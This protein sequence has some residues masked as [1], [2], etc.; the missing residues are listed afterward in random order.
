MSHPP[1]SQTSAWRQL[2]GAV[3]ALWRLESA[4]WG[5]GVA[6][7]GFLLPLVLPA[8]EN[9][10]GLIRACA[11]AALLITALDVAVLVPVRHR[12]YA[13]R[14]TLTHLEI[15]SGRVLR[16]RLSIR[17]DRVLYVDRREGPI[18]RRF[19]LVGIRIGTIVEG[20][21]LGPVAPDEADLLQGL[22]TAS[23]SG[24]VAAQ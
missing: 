15:R 21:G 12:A 18:L 5:V 14:L 20:H 17:R 16:R 11:V 4:L 22:A 6:A 23:R 19:G 2:P 10:S 7:V 8:A 24:H 13:Y 9:W 1:H 3:T